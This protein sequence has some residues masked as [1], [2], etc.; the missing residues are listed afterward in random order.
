MIDRKLTTIVPEGMDE[1]AAQ[2]RSEGDT[3]LQEI[4]CFGCEKTLSL[5]PVD[6]QFRYGPYVF[7]FRQMPG[8]ECDKPNCKQVM[9][10]AYIN[11]IMGDTVDRETARLNPPK[12]QLNP[13]ILEFRK[14]ISAVRV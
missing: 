5:R 3:F 4:N 8:Y 12:P 6:Y 10:P 2:L 9:F 7:Y 13:D 11:N 1:L 14:R